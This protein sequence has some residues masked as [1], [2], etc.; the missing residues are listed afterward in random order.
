[1]LKMRMFMKLH[2]SLLLTG[3]VGCFGL[4]HAEDNLGHEPSSMRKDGNEIIVGAPATYVET[5]MSDAVETVRPF[6]ELQPSYVVLGKEDTAKKEEE[7]PALEPMV[8]AGTGAAVAGA[9]TAVAGLFGA[10]ILLAIGALLLVASAVLTTIGWKKIKSEP[11]KY[12]GEKFAIANFIIIGVIG[13][14]ASFYAL[15]LLFVV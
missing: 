4:I 7:E 2:F 15:Y 14:A 11:K 1:M 3:I 12:R 8:L 9:G 5:D 10:P 13:V 6:V